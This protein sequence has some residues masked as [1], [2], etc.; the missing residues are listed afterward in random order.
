ML[1]NKKLLVIALIISLISAIITNSTV[2]SAFDYANAVLDEQTGLYL[3]EEFEAAGSRLSGRAVN[4]NAKSEYD[5]KED[6]IDH[7]RANL[8]SS[9]DLSTDISFPCIRHQG[10]IGSC[11]CWATTYYQ[12]GYQVAK[13]NSWNAKNS[14][15]TH[16]QFS[17]RWTHNL[18]NFG[19]NAESYEDAVYLI[20]ENQGAVRYSQFAPTGVNTDSEFRLWN[21]NKGDMTNALKYKVSSHSYLH[22]AT[23]NASTPITSYNDSDL[24][25]IKNYLNTGHVLTAATN[26]SN[27]ALATAQ[28]GTTVCTRCLYSSNICDH[29]ISIVGYNDNIACDL[30]GDG[31]IQNFEKGAFKVANSWG[32]TWGDQGYR[33]IMYDAL[34]EVSSTSVQNT[35]NRHKAF[36]KYS[37]H[38]I[39]VAEYPLDL[40]AEVTINQK[41]RNDLKIRLITSTSPSGAV[42]AQYASTLFIYGATGN[43]GPYNFTGSGTTPQTKTFV[44]D[45]SKIFNSSSV[46]KNCFLEIFKYDLDRATTISSIKLIDSS[47]KVVVNDTA[48][49]TITSDYAKYSYKI[50]VV[51]DVNNDGSITMLDITK[52]Q[53]HMSHLITLTS[54]DLKV[55]DV[56]G[57]GNVNSLDIADLQSYIAGNIT[58]FANGVMAKVN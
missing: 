19:V 24:T 47:N 16:Y 45:Y 20:L 30:N 49:K 52:I 26:M 23:E 31:S 58:V 57:E 18:T 42:Q 41:L 3:G 48:T 2:V 27:W 34:N 43:G 36:E 17:P 4:P 32:T 54:E 7:T 10:N 14:L 29:L 5:A 50:G 46:R 8:P 28:D 44:F 21:L 40:I 22:F 15:N 38:K 1:K 25:N 11:V 55:A 37:Y 12:F 53:Q 39:E 13:M 33:W 51:G 9:K 6:P 35:P 56:T